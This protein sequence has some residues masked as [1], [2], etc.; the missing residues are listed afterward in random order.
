[1]AIIIGNAANNILTGDID[2]ADLTDDIWG[3]DGNDTL[4]GLTGN[5]NLFGG[6]GNDLLDGGAGS[7]SMSGGAGNDVF[8]VD[9]AGDAVTELAGGGTDRVQ[10]SISYSLG[11]NVENLTLTGAANTSGFGNAL[12]NVIVGNSGHNYINGGAGADA[13][14]G[15]LGNDSYVVDN[16]GDSVNEGVGAGTDTVFSSIGYTLGS[17][18]ENL[19]LTGVAAINGNGNALANTLRGNSANNVLDGKAGADAMYGGLGNDSYYVDN[20]ADVV[21]EN[22]NAGIDKVFSRAANFTLGSNVENMKLLESSITVLPNGLFQINPAGVN[23]T[24]NGL[25]N[26]IEGSAVA[27]QLSGMAGNDTMY[28]LAGNDTI[29]GGAGNDWMSGGLGNDTFIVDSAADVVSELAGEGVDLVRS[30]VSYT[31]ADPHVENL[32]LTGVAN[33]SGTGNATANTIVGNSGANVINGGLGADSMHGGLGND[34]YVVDNAGDVVTEGLGAGTDHVVSSVTHTLAANVENLSLSGLGATS[35]TGNAAANSMFGNSASNTLKG[36]GGNDSIWAGA[37]NDVVQGG[38]GSDTIRGGAGND[39]LRAV[40]NVFFV[41]D[42]AEDRFVFDTALNA[43][44]NVDLIDKANFTQGGAEGVDD[45]IHLENS[46]FTALLSS[47]GTNT[48]TLGAG[49]YFEGASSGG[50]LFDPI[51]IYNVAGTGQLFYNP[52]FG[53]GGDSVLF[54]VV[55]P[56]GVAGGPAVLSVEEFTLV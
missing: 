55:N 17:N 33:I 8:V 54:A 44:T 3:Q 13:M 2:P 42:G 14:Y 5:D 24:G 22:F 1:M 40:D 43:A 6:N 38:S 35:G 32:T 47:G 51:G 25:A 23:G 27:N 20:V 37:G 52:T 29:D 11:A 16:V 50:G 53:V 18:V 4:R 41:D 9:S 34:T 31:I 36:L 56:A 39:T 19:T 30:S 15:G 10:S 45:E 12:N 21:G 49:Y 28:G 7:D 26:V 46:I 48:G